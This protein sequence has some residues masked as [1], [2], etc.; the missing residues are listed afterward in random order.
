M[1]TRKLLLN[2]L[3][4]I[5]GVATLNNFYSPHANTYKGGLLYSRKLFKSYLEDKLIEKIEPIGKAANKAREVFYCLTKRGAD[6]IG[7]PDEYRYKKYP[8]SPNNALHESMKF[9]IALA[10]L[11]LYPDK[12]FTFRYDSSFYGVRPDILIRIEST[13]PKE[14]TRFLMVEIERKKTVDRVF[15]EKIMRYEEMFKAIEQKKSHNLDQ[16]LTLFVYTDI[17]YDGYLRPQQ[18]NEPQAIE[19]IGRANQLVKNLVNQYCRNLPPN[20]YR[21]MPFHDFYRL[22][23]AVWYMT[24]GNRISLSIT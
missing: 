16:F 6:Y 2:N 20:R 1:Q 12:K 23:K 15:H 14:V 9:D 3:L 22:D 17:W 8:R 18:Y 4:D 19:Y 7:R 13:N 21:Y 5:G 24:D 11:R 10:F